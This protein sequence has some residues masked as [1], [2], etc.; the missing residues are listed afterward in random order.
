MATR[1]VLTY[2][3]YEALPEGDGRHYQILDGELFVTASPAPR[4]QRILGRLNDIVRRHVLDR[5]LGEVLFAPVAVILADTTV[6]EPDLVYLDR[7]RQRLVSARAIDGPPTLVVEI[8][9]P[10]T[11]AVDR[12]TKR[13]LYSRYGVPFYWIVDPV[14]R[15]LE[16]YALGEGAD[17]LVTR[18]TGSMSM[19]LPPFPDLAFAPDSLWPSG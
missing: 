17:T 9:S 14:A 6:V 18:A 7:E 5:G 4:H 8:L 2:R 12:G 11:A 19:S 1:V 3:D 16:A 10:S 15:S 13:Q